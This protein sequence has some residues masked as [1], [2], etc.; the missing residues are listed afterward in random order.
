MNQKIS[1][2]I[3]AEIRLFNKNNYDLVENEFTINSNK[4]TVGN[5]SADI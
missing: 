3:C 2:L 4:Y 1:Y 5:D